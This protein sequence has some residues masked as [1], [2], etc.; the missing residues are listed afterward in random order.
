VCAGAVSPVTSH[1]LDTALG[2]PAAGVLICLQRAAQGSGGTAW[3]TLGE[4]RTNA[5]GRVPHLLP[6]GNHIAPG[7][8]PAAVSSALQAAGPGVQGASLLWT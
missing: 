3:D 5:D 8:R 7:A 2:R 6:P 4:A 1:V